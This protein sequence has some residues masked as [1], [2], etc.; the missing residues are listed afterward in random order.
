MRVTE[1]EWVELPAL[2]SHEDFLQLMS[3]FDELGMVSRH[4]AI[5]TYVGHAG[6]QHAYCVQVQPSDAR[7]VARVLREY[8]A[9]EDPSSETPYTGQ[10]A[11]CGE[12]VEAVW[13]CPSCGISF[14]PRHREDDALVAFIREHGGF[15]QP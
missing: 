2:L 12:D 9:V 3:R 13:T 11:A 7:R 5:N 15:T 8:W 14:R 6:A 1:S 10:C 4:R